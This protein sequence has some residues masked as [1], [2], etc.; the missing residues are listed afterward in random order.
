MI[1]YYILEVLFFIS[2]SQI[3]TQQ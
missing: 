1:S 3:P 2:F